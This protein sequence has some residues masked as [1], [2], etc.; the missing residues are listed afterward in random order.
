MRAFTTWIAATLLALPALATARD[1]HQDPRPGPAPGAATTAESTRPSTPG[2]SRADLAIQQRPSRPEPLLAANT[3]IPRTLPTVPTPEMPRVYAPTRS[4]EVYTRHPWRL[5]ITAT[6]FWIGETPTANNPTPNNK[7]SW[8]S[9]WERNFGG[10]DDPNPERRR[11]FRPVNIPNPGQNPF[12][13]ALPYNDVIDWRRHKPEASEIIPWFNDRF[14]RPGRTVLK[15]QWL[16]IRYN[17]RICFAQWEDCGPFTTDDP[18]YVFG[19]SPPSN[20]A[21]S[22][23]GIDISPAVRDYLGVRSHQQVDWRFVDLD[24]VPDGPWRRWGENN[25]FVNPEGWADT[26]HGSGNPNN[27]APGNGPVGSQ[28]ALQQEYLERLDELRRMRDEWFRQHGT[29]GRQRR[30]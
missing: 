20:T 22:N 19:D 9:E 12:Y 18:D 25:P 7:S 17:G 1:R 4:R 5:G 16:A 24:E 10:Y 6:V 28:D 15:G 23:A 21:N 3:S 27:I 8:D 11:D 29:D 26:G 14:E 30:Y 13:I 2:V